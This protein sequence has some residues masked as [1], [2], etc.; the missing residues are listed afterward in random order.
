MPV[1]SQKTKT[2]GTYPE[3]PGTT[4]A[5]ERLKAIRAQPAQR[6]NPNSRRKSPNG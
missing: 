6:A 4:G 2:K 5:A 1:A 3:E